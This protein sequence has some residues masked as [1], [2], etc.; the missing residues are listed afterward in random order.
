[1]FRDTL[2]N[3][4]LNVC[5]VYNYVKQQFNCCVSKNAAYHCVLGVFVMYT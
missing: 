3:V 1:M 5:C 2:G 4:Y